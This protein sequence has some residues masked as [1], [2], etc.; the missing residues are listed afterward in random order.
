[1]RWLLVV[2]LGIFL[3]ACEEP[4][5]L[6]DLP[7]DSGKPVVMCN[8]TKGK[9][10]IVFVS[11]TKS[12][13]AV[14]QETVYPDD[15]SVK[16]YQNKYQEEYLSFYDAKGTPKPPFYYSTGLNP[17]PG[18]PFFLEVKIPG[19]K[20]LTATSTIPRPSEVTIRS[21][22]A[23]K[24]KIG[25][26]KTRVDYRIRISVKDPL[27]AANYY[28]LNFYQKFIQHE[29]G[30]DTVIIKGPLAAEFETDIPFLTHFDGRGILFDDAAFE[31]QNLFLV[32]TGSFVQTSNQDLDDFFV[33]LISGSKE[34]YNY[35]TSLSRQ[36]STEA[37]ELTE[38]VVID[39][40]ITNGYGVFAGYSMSIDSTFV[41][42]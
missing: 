26:F 37:S 34:Y 9:P 27:Y 13:L 41:G 35:L 21:F 17:L 18:V 7:D 4:V 15:A 24:K 8:F 5:D 23:V 11:K 6:V 22:T 14:A 16:I 1:M 40:N 10:V 28:H 42:N 33:E 3:S 2:I 39:E 20:M 38:A 19:E 30:K 25:H 32:A 29:F 36:I 12:S 31:G